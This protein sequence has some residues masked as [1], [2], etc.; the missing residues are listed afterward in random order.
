M[1]FDPDSHPPIEP[2]AGAA[3]EH[4][5]LELQAADGNRLGAFHAAGRGAQRRGHAGAA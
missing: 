4:R 1:C 2:I 3:I 5:V